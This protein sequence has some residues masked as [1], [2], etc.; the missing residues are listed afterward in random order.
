[1]PDEIVVENPVDEMVEEL[2]ADLFPA[3]GA[4]GEEHD[5]AATDESNASESAEPAKTAAEPASGA[6]PSDKS[7]PASG[8]AP[9]EADPLASA[10]ASWGKDIAATWATLPPDVK[11]MIAKREED[12]KVGFNQLNNL[13]QFGEGFRKAVE[14]LLPTLQRFGLEPARH[15]AELMQVHARLALGT[16]QQK[17]ET[18][19]GL[20]KQFGLTPDSL[21]DGAQAPFVDP[22]VQSLTTQFQ[23]LQSTQQRIVQDNQSRE[24]ARVTAEVND[25]RGKNPHF[26]TVQDD[27][28]RLLESKAYPNL[29]AAYQ[30]AIWANPVVRQKILDEQAAAKKADDD[31]AK[32]DR[33]A[34]ARQS[35][36][37]NVRSTPKSRGPTAP[38]GSIDDTLNEVA[39]RLFADAQ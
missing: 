13:A 1:M 30:A 22:A 33:A 34:K 20:M 37:A 29:E 11:K 39:N 19:L 27:I 31:K 36:A 38:K 6:L 4:G 3:A 7:A 12:V 35:T 18:F 8:A 5:D 25:F 15:A 14:P 2:S 21:V 16:P 24:V 10:P 32:A 23:Q 26:D 28:A 17:V 9:G